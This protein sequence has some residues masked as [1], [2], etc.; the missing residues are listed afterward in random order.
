MRQWGDRYLEREHQ[1]ERYLD[2]EI[3]RLLKEPE[4][5]PELEYKRA[6]GDEDFERWMYGDE[7]DKRN[8]GDAERDR[9]EWELLDKD[10]HKA[11][12][13]ERSLGRRTTYK[14]YQTESAGR[15]LDFHEKHQ[16]REARARW[17]D[18]A[19]KFPEACQRCAERI[20]VA[21]S[22]RPRT[23]TSERARA[24]FRQASRWVDPVDREMRDLIDREFK[25]LEREGVD[26]LGT[27]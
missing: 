24:R 20:A 3:D 22:T 1:L 7:R 18:I 12:K 17:Q 2:K 8:R 13:P 11:F 14:Q 27:A 10:L 4:R 19:E 21:R 15:L 23:A 6:R 9:R 16:E 26:P 5:V 25:D